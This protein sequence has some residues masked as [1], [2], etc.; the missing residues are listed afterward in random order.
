MLSVVIFNRNSAAHLVACLKSHKQHR[1]GSDDEVILVDNAS[2]DGSI[3]QASAVFP[4]LR[5]VANER[6]VGFAVGNNL[7]LAEARGQYVL[8]LNP[9][10][11]FLASDMSALFLLLEECPT[12]GLVGCRLRNPD[13]TPQPSCHAFPTLPRLVLRRSLGKTA[14][15]REA[16]ARSAGLRPYLLDGWSPDKACS[17]DW[18]LG[19]FMLGRRE[20]LLALGGF[21]ESFHFYATDVELCWRTWAAGYEVRYSP[22]YEIIHYGNPN[23]SRER[24]NAVRTANSQFVSTYR[25][26]LSGRLLDLAYRGLNLMERR[27]R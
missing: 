22:E 20:T 23:W 11:R 26:R 21:D 2:S 25:S 24:L 4:G 15:G 3:A 18:V 1:A 27:R 8:F 9:D 17:V 13:M 7:G 14:V 12:L 19:A 10:T 16:G 5:V 6:D